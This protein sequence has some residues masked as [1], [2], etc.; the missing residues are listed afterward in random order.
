MRPS[1]RPSMRP[2][3]R[4]ASVALAATLF[5]AACGSEDSGTSAGDGSS[6]GT[7]VVDTLP[8]TSS[9]TVADTTPD[10]T[11]TATDTATDADTDTD[12]DTD[13]DTDTAEPGQDLDADTA[14]AS[15][16]LLTF[17]DLPEGW[18]ESPRAE[19][20]SAVDA[21]LAACVGVEGDGLTAADATARSGRFVAPD[22]ALALTQ[23]VGVLATEREA[24]TVVAF[25]AEPDVPSCVA[26]AY[27]EV[28]ADVL[29]ASLAEGAALGTP[30]AIRLQVGSAGDATQA[31]RVVVPVTG[32]PAV[33]E[34]TID[35]VIV[36]SGRAL[37][38]LT[39]ENRAGATPVETIDEITAIIASRLAD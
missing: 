4:V 18:T 19:A 27:G 5:V 21:R 28:G 23:D 15:A 33:V 17:A 6:S 25:A 30:T 9:D 11:D 12:I 24:R 14:S 13:T 36:R 31:I 22:G 16:A 8:D 3:A 38:S 20:S 35:H 32:D 10:T 7:A 29:G 2:A 26:A 1:M 34:V 39:F 37:A